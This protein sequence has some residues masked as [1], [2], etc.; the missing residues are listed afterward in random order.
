MARD[1][2]H[3][4]VDVAVIHAAGWEPDH[5]VAAVRR[6][7]A[8]QPARPVLIIQA[9]R[10]AQA[11]VLGAF[12][13]QVVGPDR[14]IDGACLVVGA[15]PIE[16]GTVAVINPDPE[17]AGVAAEVALTAQAFGATVYL[18]TERDHAPTDVDC[19]V[20]VAGGFESPLVDGLAAGIQAARVARANGSHDPEERQRTDHVAALK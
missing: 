4:S 3:E 16:R 20:V 10:A 19:T 14:L 5:L 8:G 18:V 17:R 6:H 2:L 1:E 12:D 7:R 9:T 13:R 15:M 11:A